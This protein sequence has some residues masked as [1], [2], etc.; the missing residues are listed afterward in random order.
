M[1]CRAYKFRLCL[2]KQQQSTAKYKGVWF[3]VKKSTIYLPK[4]AQQQ[5]IKKITK[6]KHITSTLKVL[7]LNQK[8]HIFNF[9]VSDW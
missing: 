4:R 6:Y 8:D 3:F 5:K 7:K 2:I 9:A 1:C